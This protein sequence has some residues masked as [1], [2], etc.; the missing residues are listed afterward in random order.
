MAPNF[1]F[2]RDFKL[3]TKCIPSVPPG[4]DDESFYC[5]LNTSV[6]VL[7]HNPGVYWM[8]RWVSMRVSQKKLRSFNI[9]KS[10]KILQDKFYSASLK[11]TYSAIDAKA[12]KENLATRFKKG[13]QE[14]LD[15]F[16]TFVLQRMHD[17]FLERRQ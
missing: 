8:M 9:I 7:L 2:I 13:S 11:H 6:Q 5:Y 10:F 3:N 15:E 14:D 4:L 16:L 12:L 17:E 1:K